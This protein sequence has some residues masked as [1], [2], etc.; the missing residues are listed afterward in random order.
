MDEHGREIGEVEFYRM[1]HTDHHDGTFIRD[2]SREIYV[3]IYY[4]IVY[5]MI[6]V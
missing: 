1:T 6:L 4:N 5:A 3:L 2:E